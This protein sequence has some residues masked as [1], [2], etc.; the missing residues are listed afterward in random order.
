MSLFGK[1]K[2]DP[3]TDLAPNSDRGFDHL[4]YVVQPGQ[5]IPREPKMKGSG[6]TV[7]VLPYPQ[8]DVPD[9]KEKLLVHPDRPE[10]SETE[11]GDQ[12]WM[13]VCDG[14]R[15]FGKNSVTLLFDNPDD[16]GF[17]VREHHPVGLIVQAAWAAFKGGMVSTPLGTSDSDG[18]YE[19][20]KGNDKKQNCYACLPGPD[21]LAIMNVLLYSLG[22]QTYPVDSPLGSAKNE[23]QVLWVMS[24]ATAGE[25]L[26]VLRD[27]DGNPLPICGSRV[28]HFY[29]KK[30]PASC[31][32][33]TN[34]TVAGQGSFEFG[35]RRRASPLGPGGQSQQQLAGFTVLATD[36]LSGSPGDN[37]KPAMFQQSLV[38]YACEKLLPWERVLRGHTPDQCAQIIATKCGLPDSLLYHAWQGHKKWYSE[39]IK[40]KL[41]NPVTLNMGTGPAH[42]QPMQQTAAATHAAAPAQPTG[43]LDMFA[44]FGGDVATPPQTAPRS[45]D[46]PMGS[47]P[48]DG[49]VGDAEPPDAAELDGVDR[50]KVEQA[51]DMFRQAMNRRKQGG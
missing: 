12:R 29:D 26:K 4:S 13:F 37:L 7:V 5:A 3:N 8:F 11:F 25:F 24:R 38:K 45:G 15:K 48:W 14:V 10:Q 21:R 20:L 46:F 18:W 36:S 17:D 27:K 50:A 41:S 9:Y 51:S 30:N 34:S 49:P 16:S 28:F 39:Q 40:Y 2:F 42:H 33:L 35:D 32:A 43:N 44:G 47:A 6:G 19:L 22:V 31:Q 1:K 23:P